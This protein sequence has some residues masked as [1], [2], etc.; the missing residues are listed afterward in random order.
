[1]LVSLVNL[2]EMASAVSSLA[3]QILNRTIV[4]EHSCA[5]RRFYH[6][7]RLA[8]AGAC[9]LAQLHEELVMEIL[10]YLERD[11][12]TVKSVCVMWRQ[13]WG[14]L[15]PQAGDHVYI[16]H[17][18]VVRGYL[19]G[20]GGMHEG[21]PV[22]IR[23]IP[24]AAECRQITGANAEWVL[25]A[26]LV[27]GHVALST[28]DAAAGGTMRVRLGAIALRRGGESWWYDCRRLAAEADLAVSGAASVGSGPAM[29]AFHAR[30]GTE[31]A[32]AL[33]D[34]DGF[35]G[36]DVAMTWAARWHELGV[37]AI[38]AEG[39]LYHAICDVGELAVNA[40]REAIG[41]AAIL[42]GLHEVRGLSW[43]EAGR[44]LLRTVQER[45]RELRV[46]AMLHAVQQAHKPWL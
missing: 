8:R 38:D 41:S 21:R 31:P 32:L 7:G 20:D 39:L 19:S 36:V 23:A 3:D 11:D 5:P 35:I 1:M 2:I 9:G 42:S 44:E 34:G 29:A 25:R 18:A 45:E 15:R 27:P 37:P 46:L 26:E 43:G 14:Q 28:A 17:G 30:F 13:L 10:A 4:L 33:L 6:G 12:E 24:T 22:T 40:A 16:G